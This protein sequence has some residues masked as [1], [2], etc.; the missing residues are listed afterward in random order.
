MFSSIIWAIFFFYALIFLLCPRIGLVF[1]DVYFC[2]GW[3]FWLASPTWNL[4]SLIYGMGVFILIL[5][6]Y[7]VRSGYFHHVRE[8]FALVYFVYR[9]FHR[10]LNAEAL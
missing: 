1:D 9:T 5:R 6:C 7:P 3:F 4:K 8:M 10:G 2:T